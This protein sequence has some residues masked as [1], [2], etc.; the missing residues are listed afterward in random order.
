M[1]LGQ[2]FDH[3]AGLGAMRAIV[4]GANGG[5]GGRVARPCQA[6][7]SDA[8]LPTLPSSTKR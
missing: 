6:G 5:Q 3:L 2:S 4:S 1:W 8:S 7:D